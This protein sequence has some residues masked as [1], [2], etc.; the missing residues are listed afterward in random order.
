PRCTDETAL[1]SVRSSP[2]Q[3][4]SAQH[5]S[6]LEADAVRRPVDEEDRADE[7]LPWN[8]TPLARVARLR[9]VVAHHEVAPRGNLPVLSDVALVELARLRRDIRLVELAEDRR[10]GS[11]DPDEA[12]VVL[13]E[14]LAGQ[15]DDAL[16]EGSP[17]AAIGLGRL[18]RVEDDDVAP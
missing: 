12:L 16:D 3:R 7:V 8:G 2:T 9:P 13:L 17:F 14:G 4:A 15:A 5:S 1:S 10:L 6:L 18:R 11:S